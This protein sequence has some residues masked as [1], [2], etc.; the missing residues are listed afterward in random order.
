ML[1]SCRVLAPAKI[2]IGLVVSPGTGG[3]HNIESVFQTVDLCDELA[4]ETQDA[5]GVIVRCAGADIP[6]QNTLTVAFEAFCEEAAVLRQSPVRDAGVFGARV[7]L[8]KR[9]PQG[10]GLG[11]GSSDAAAFVRALEMVYGVRLDRAAKTRIAAKTGSDVFF[12]M[13]AFSAADAGC[14]FDREGN[15]PVKID[16][17][18]AVVT[19]RGEN[20]KRIGARNDLFFV[21]V[22]PGVCVSTREAFALLDAE[23]GAGGERPPALGELEAMYREGAKSWRFVN[24][25]TKPVSRVFP[26][27]ARALDDVKETGAAFTGMSGSGSAVFGVFESRGAADDAVRRLKLKWERC[28]GIIQTAA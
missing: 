1:G 3:Y 2:N 20:V 17:F 5:A 25:F 22:Y 28:W 6:A 26:D 7:A 18:A 15:L 23:R 27:I 10:A 12:F 9:I 14:S 24:S 16:A 21:L 11:G 19:G 13:E 4:V 8:M